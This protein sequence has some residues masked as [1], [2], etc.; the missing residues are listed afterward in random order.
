MQDRV[1]NLV[2]QLQERSVFRALVAYGV[3]AWML[4]Q[5]AD[6]TFDRLPIP[7][8]SMTVLIVLVVIGFPVVAIVAWAYELTA[9]GIVRH[10]DAGTRAPRMAF[11][12]FVAVVAVVAVGS[13]SLLYYLSQNFWEAPRRSIAVLPFTNTSG[14]AETE[15]F[16][17]GLT[18]EIQ[19]LIVR[20][21]EF[22]VVAL[23]TTRQFK[24][25]LMDAVSIADQLGAE[26]V[27]LG[28]VRRYQGKVSVTARLIDGNDGRE[29]WSEKYDRELSDIYAIQEDIARHVARALHVV[30]PVAAERRLKN[31]GTGNVEAYDAYLRGI[32]FLRK[33]P[34]ETSLLMAEGL[35]REALAIDPDYANAHA[36]MCRKHLAAY[37]LSADAQRFGSA[38]RA[39]Q[40]ALEHGGE[41]VD[42]RLVLGWLYLASGRNEDALRAFEG[43]RDANNHLAEAYV[44]L[45]RAQ[46]ALDRVDDAEANLRLAIATDA[47]YWRAFNEMGN[48]MFFQGRYGEAAEFYQMFVDRVDDDA[49]ALNNLGAAHYLSGDFRK[50]AEAWDR[51]IEIKPTRSAYSNTGTMYFYLG[52]FERAIERYVN[53]ANLAPNDHRVWGNLGDAYYFQGDQKQVAEVAYKRAIELGESL[54]E[55]NVD[56]VQVISD[57]ALYCARIG[58]T[59]RALELDARATSQGPGI[60]Y[61]HYNSALIHVQFGELDKA[62]AALERA[63]ELS[64]ERELLQIDPALQ[65]LRDHERFRQLVSNNRT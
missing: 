31:L 15:Y 21:N 62:L 30:L 27:L 56:D 39:C 42:V 59:A 45:A 13:G 19:S 36:A 53:A 1:R 64:Y 44:G 54:L 58:D 3:V 16:S 4:L 46:Q 37:E 12:P 11:L 14:E 65:P 8:N 23:S 55:I 20:L 18:E 48:F 35:L 51:S 43:A 50:A 57:M 61:V 41:S 63:V 2:R 22:R 10:G 32:D 17:E 33:P 29:L 5:V 40:Q 60:M 6:V 28:S 7:R 24:D 38:E 26:A 47:S 25:S 34:D 52:D 49:Q 9:R